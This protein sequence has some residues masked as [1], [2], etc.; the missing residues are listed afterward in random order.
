MQF[1]TD[2]IGYMLTSNALL[3]DCCYVLIDKTI[4]GGTTWIESLNEE[5]NAANCHANVGYADIEFTP[6]E[7]GYALLGRFILKTPYET[8][9]IEDFNKSNSFTMYPNPTA[10]GNFNLKFDVSNLEGVSIEIVDV[11]GR[12]LYSQTDLEKDN[13]ISIPALSEGIYFV[14]L[15]NNGK[16]IAAQKL[17]KL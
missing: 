3:C 10:N 14:N 9:S 15:L 16:M 7:I 17:L 6:G 1:L 8:A 4:D 12:N 11:N 13:N 2:D 5:T